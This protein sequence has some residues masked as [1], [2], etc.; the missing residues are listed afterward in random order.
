M[1]N[2]A[3]ATAV[4][5]MATTAFALPAQSATLLQATG[6]INGAAYTANLNL[7]VVNGQAQSG[8]GTISFLSFVNAPITLI[9]TAT[10]GNI[11]AGGPTYP[12]GFRA[13][14][15]T[16]LYGADQAYPL[17]EGGLLFAVGTTS[18]SF[19]ANPLINFYSNGSTLASVFTGKVDGVEH[20][21]E[22]GSL[23]V[24]AVPEPATWGLMLA[25]FGMIGFAA[26]RGQSVK[27]KITYA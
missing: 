16:D 2:F 12:V 17:T 23:S 19:G 4:A 1:K 20:Y 18:P 27:T 26:R 25:G 9:T 8:T 22:Y 14:D 7:D 5:L 13:N 24:A 15:G 21:V 10:N 11:T 6:T 3:L